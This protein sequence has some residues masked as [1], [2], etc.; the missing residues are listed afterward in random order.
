MNNRKIINQIT[1]YILISIFVYII[2]NHFSLSFN[3]DN[4]IR[5]AFIGVILELIWNY[6]FE[7]VLWRNSIIRLIFN[8]KTPVIH[9]RWEGYVESSFDNF[10]KKFPVVLEIFQ[11]YST[12]KITYYDKRAVSH[13]I[14]SRLIIEEGKPSQLLCIYRNEPYEV[15]G[16]RDST[17]RT[18]YGVMILTLLGNRKLMGIYFNKPV[19][20]STYGKIYLEF[21]SR[22]LKRAFNGDSY[23]K[24]YTKHRK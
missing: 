13:T 17:L 4:L 3:F 1:E 21:S 22:N 10:K 23:V 2:I 12:L 6:T 11:T 15:R 24:E 5:S 16:E 9:G 20:R 14:A 18:H 8:I 7:K 19:E